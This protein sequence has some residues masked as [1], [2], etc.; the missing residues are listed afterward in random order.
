MYIYTTEEQ[1]CALFPLPSEE[2]TPELIARIF[3]R[4]MDKAIIWP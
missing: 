4:R 2:G 3:P 1:W